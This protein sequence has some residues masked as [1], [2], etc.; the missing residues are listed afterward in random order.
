MLLGP[1]RLQ[2]FKKWIG[3]HNLESLCWLPVHCPNFSTVNICG[4]DESFM[5]FQVCGNDTVVH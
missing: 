2:T 5:S 4:N 1:H 3:I